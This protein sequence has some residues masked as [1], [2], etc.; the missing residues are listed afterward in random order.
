M[1]LF[2]AS[3]VVEMFKVAGLVWAGL[4]WANLD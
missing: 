3:H 1:A 2:F 4:V